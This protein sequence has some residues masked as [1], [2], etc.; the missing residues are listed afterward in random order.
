MTYGQSSNTT[1]F[2]PFAS[3]FLLDAFDRCKIYAPEGKHLQSGR[4]SF[5]FLLS[6]KWSNLGINLWKMTE[7]ILPLIPGVIEY[8]LPKSV[9]SVYDC[10]R[11]QYPMNGPQ[12]YA[13]AF[14]TVIST[15]NVTIAIPGQSSPVGSYINISIPIAVGGLVLYGFYQ[16]TA[17]PTANSITIHAAANA[18]ASVTAG[19]AV[20]IFTT[21]ANSQNVSVNLPN[22]GLVAGA[23]FPVAVATT[24]G[25]ITLS[26]NYII[27]SITDANHFVILASSNAISGATQAENGGL[28]QI[29]LQNTLAGYSDILMTQYS[30]TD[31]AS[32][33]DKTAPGAPTCLWVN[34]QE[35]PVFSVWPVT[36]A[37][38]PYEI[39]LWCQMQIDDVNPTAGQTVDLVQRFFYPCV[40]DLA[41]D[42]ALKF[43]EKDQYD[44]V[45]AAATAAWEQAEGTDVENTST[46]VL[47]LM[48][49]G[50]G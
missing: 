16:V 39:H 19:G 50:L 47:P 31:Y 20:P 35:I 4:R 40:M 21:T 11:R 37:T 38:G 2:A 27:Q 34:K 13:V 24:V 29:S 45:T 25:G 26:G 48:P 46:F 28:A 41:Q 42:L 3:D 33:A 22:H 1:N 6:S 9:V 7:V 12:S 17:T 10:Y 44:R 14:T 18:T 8:Y 23:T 15:P 43:C 30:R 49:T 5:N 36:D 32:Q